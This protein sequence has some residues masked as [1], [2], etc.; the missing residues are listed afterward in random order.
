MKWA[1]AYKI[2]SLIAV[3]CG[4]E[5]A[6]CVLCEPHEGKLLFVAVMTLEAHESSEFLCLA[7][8]IRLKFSCIANF[9]INIC[10]EALKCIKNIQHSF[11]M[12]CY[13]K[14][15]EKIHRGCTYDINWNGGFIPN[16]GVSIL[17]IAH[18]VYD[19]YAHTKYVNCY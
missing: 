5:L 12:S 11:S 4:S 2:P 10:L 16:K 14:I 19:T 9:I 7:K 3:T 1:H 18:I 17:Y 13:V 6:K 8:E 15:T